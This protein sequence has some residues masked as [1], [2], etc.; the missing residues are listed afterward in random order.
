MCISRAVT[1][2]AREVQKLT[3]QDQLV[4]IR[5]LEEPPEKWISDGW[6]ATRVR[7]EC[8]LRIEQGLKYRPWTAN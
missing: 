4:C 5:H 8:Q 1:K 6:T 7:Q 3:H 2:V